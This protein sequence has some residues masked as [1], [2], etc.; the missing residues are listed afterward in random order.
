MRDVKCGRGGLVCGVDRDNALYIRTGPSH[1]TPIGRGWART[2]C[3]VKTVAMGSQYIATWLINDTILFGRPSPQVQYQDFWPLVWDGLENA[4]PPN[5]SHITM[6]TND[7]LYGVTMTGDVYHVKGIHTRDDR[8]DWA[9]LSKAPPLARRGGFLSSLLGLSKTA[10]LFD[11]VMATSECVWCLRT[12]PLELW[13]LTVRDVLMGFAIKYQT[14]WN[15]F[16]FDKSIDSIAS[17]SGDSDDPNHIYALTKSG[18]AVFVLDVTGPCVTA[19]EL[20]YHKY[21]DIIL[22]SLSVSS[23]ED[24]PT[25]EQSS[26]YPKLPKR[27]RIE[28]EEGGKEEGEREEVSEESNELMSYIRRGKRTHA[29]YYTTAVMESGE[30]TELVKRK[31]NT[32]SSMT[33]PAKVQS[34][35]CHLLCE[36][37]LCMI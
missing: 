13:Q 36:Y 6:D 23:I 11:S 4:T 29:G 37:L 30:N 21:G 26:I 16:K 10:S 25:D 18:D 27:I 33:S 3:T 5:M 8:L 2:G 34:K 28:I 32:S 20:P 1:A 19:S 31:R 35:I 24:T 17:I 14:S 12:D 7:T 15:R 9:H 22:T